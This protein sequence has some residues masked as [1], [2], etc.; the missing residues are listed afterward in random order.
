MEP[1]HGKHSAQQQQNVEKM[2]MMF[3]KTKKASGCKYNSGLFFVVKTKVF[4]NIFK[5]VLQFIKTSLFLLTE[6]V[7]LPKLTNTGTD[8]GTVIITKF[9]F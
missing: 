3:I 5:K 4:H 1:K 9:Y 6:L 2:H 8:T 7:A